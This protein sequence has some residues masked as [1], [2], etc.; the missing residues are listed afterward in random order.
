VEVIA[1]ERKTAVLRPSAVPCLRGLS[2]INLTEG[3]ALGCV[4]CYAQ[5]YTRYP[6]DGRVAVFADTPERLR[7]EL[8]RKRKWPRRVCFSSASD[9]FQ[10]LPQV[11]DAAFR[12]MQVLLEAGIEVA[13]L[14]KGFVGEQF[15]A[16]FR[17]CPGRVFAQIG[18]TTLDRRWWAAFEPRTAPPALRLD[19][20]R[21]LIDSG[22]PTTARLDPLIPDLT[23]T[24]KNLVPLLAALHRAGVRAAAAS[25]LFLRSAFAARVNGRI[26]RL[27]GA[28]NSAWK[29]VRFDGGLSG[30]RVIATGERQRRFARLR[31]L[32][33]SVGIRLNV[34]RCKNPDVVAGRC[35][36]AGR[37]FESGGRRGEQRL[38]SFARE[39]E[40][41]SAAASAGGDSRT[42]GCS[43]QRPVGG[44]HPTRC[45]P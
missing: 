4:Y 28:E 41:T 15:F 43:H 3:C 23:D 32:A 2:V 31:A 14:T 10:D 30:G 26:Q 27:G 45:G 34:C 38:L 13:L 1:R 11:Q 20:M 40:A 29:Y 6:G 22:V 36:V 21:A 18:I 37:G 39:P 24:A 12:T 5:G 33:D 25:Y 35:E 8:R 7:A 19:T 16:L 17:Q 44:A 42:R 9:A